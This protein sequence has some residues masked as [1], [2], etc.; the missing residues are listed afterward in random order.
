MAAS[1]RLRDGPRSRLRSSFSAITPV[2]V[3]LLGYAITRA[4]RRLE[5]AHWAGRKLIERRLDLYDEM[6]PLLNDPSCFFLLV[7]N[8]RAITPPTQGAT[9]TECLLKIQLTPTSASDDDQQ[10]HR[11]REIAARARR[12]G[13]LRPRPGATLPPAPQTSHDVQALA[14]AQ[15]DCCRT[16]WVAPSPA[17][18]VNDA[19]DG[20]PLPVHA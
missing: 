11:C 7:G 3:A 2:V 15:R 1:P 5:D 12:S 8:Y 13:S 14:A 17:R 4:V 19:V 9:A 10:S 6:A 16:R 18:G 20:R